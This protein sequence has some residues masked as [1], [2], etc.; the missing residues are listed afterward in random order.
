MKIMLYAIN[1]YA[2]CNLANSRA[3]PG[4][5]PGRPA[6]SST[7]RWAFATAFLNN[8]VQVS[9][10]HTTRAPPMCC[11]H[12]S[13]IQTQDWSITEPNIRIN[14]RPNCL[15]TV[16]DLAVFIQPVTDKMLARWDRLG[17][18]SRTSSKVSSSILV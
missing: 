12:Q 4:R 11:L 17:R 18:L 9:S 8:D 13:R 6:E 15:S 2:P 5:L 1:S 16:R 3:R 14:T 7:K 10:G